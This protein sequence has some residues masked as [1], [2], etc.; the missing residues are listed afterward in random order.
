MPGAEGHLDR[1]L[2]DAPETGPERPAPKAHE[3]T[4]P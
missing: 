1:T 4:C 2:R 3:W